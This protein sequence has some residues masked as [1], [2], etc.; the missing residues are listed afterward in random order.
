MSKD[1]IDEF[2]ELG[3]E[4]SGENNE[5]NQEPTE[6]EEKKTYTEEEVKE[7]LAKAQEES[8]KTET[9]N[10]S[11]SSLAK[12]IADTLAQNNKILAE[13]IAKKDE[14][15]DSEKYSQDGYIDEE[16][17]DP[18]D[19][20]EKPIQF[21]CHSIGYVIVDDKRNGFSSINPYRKKAIEFKYKYSKRKGHGSEQ[22][23]DH[24]S[25]Y[26]CQ[27]KKEAEWLRNHS[28]FGI[29]FFDKLADAMSVGDRQSMLFAQYF[30]TVQDMDVSLVRGE[31]RR[32][33][34]PTY[35]DISKQRV[36]LATAM[37][38]ER[39]DIEEESNRKRTV[40]ALKEKYAESK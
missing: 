24:F 16:Y 19:E 17:I 6:Q 31:S 1:L 7:L 36:S 26:L 20:L 21:F 2:E 28:Y 12:V 4:F 39:I 38:K 22:N 34:L 3:A 30:N 32:R 5:S 11:D 29:K 40:D 13:A 23:I 9:N 33:E 8:S 27:S 15:S 35:E 18:E 14:K 25:V 10:S 37:A